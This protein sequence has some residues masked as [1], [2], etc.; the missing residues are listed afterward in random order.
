MK[1]SQLLFS[2]IVNEQGVFLGRV[3]D[4]RCAPPPQNPG[5]ASV[6]ELVYGIGGFLERLGLREVKTETIA[7]KTVISL[8]QKQIVVRKPTA[9]RVPSR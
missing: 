7:W 5:R 2:K 9:K 8:G 1:I 6:R 3:I 4:V